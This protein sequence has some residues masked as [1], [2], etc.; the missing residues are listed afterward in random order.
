MHVDMQNEK[1]DG[2]AQHVYDLQSSIVNLKENQM[3]DIHEKI[4][5]NTKRFEFYDYQMKKIESKL[6]DFWEVIVNSRKVIQSSVK[7]NPFITMMQIS[8]F[9]QE[10]LCVP[11]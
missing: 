1:I 4:K 10:F 11:D 5:M 8:D 3:E 6:E 7:I 9:M 2:V